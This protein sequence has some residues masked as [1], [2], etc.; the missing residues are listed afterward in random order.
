[1]LI[2]D[3]TTGIAYALG[4][5]LFLICVC[6]D[7]YLNERSEK[8]RREGKKMN[9]LEHY[10]L[11]IIEETQIDN[12]VRVTVKV[13]CHGCQETINRVFNKE[14]WEEAKEKGFFMA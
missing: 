10:I 9:L 12:Y 7:N 6:I 14:E 3:L 5:C 2:S 13:D 11:E 4:C 8:K 1:M